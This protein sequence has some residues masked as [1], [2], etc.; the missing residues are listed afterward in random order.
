MDESDSSGEGGA[1]M[2]LH[3]GKE[4]QSE[5]S[6]SRLTTLNEQAARENNEV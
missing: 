4:S 6:P 1:G 5:R 3:K 2:E